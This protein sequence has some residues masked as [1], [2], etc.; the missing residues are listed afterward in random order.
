MSVGELVGRCRR[1]AAEGEEVLGYF[2]GVYGLAG[3][4]A[5]RERISER[6]APFISDGAASVGATCAPDVTISGVAAPA[7]LELCDRVR[8]EGER[9]EIDASLYP[10]ATAGFRLAADDGILVL[11][12]KTGSLCVLRPDERIAGVFNPTAENLELDLTRLAKSLVSLHCEARGMA[13]LHASG[14]VTSGGCVLFAGDSRN[15]KTTT[16]LESMAGF[17]LALLSC[18][19]S[20]VSET[21][22]GLRARGWPSNFSVSIG[23]MLDFPDLHPHLDPSMRELGYA[24]AW[25]IHP[26]HVLDTHAVSAAAGWETRPEADLEVIVALELSTEGNGVGIAPCSGEQLD[27]FLAGVTLGS[28]DPLYPDWHRYWQH[29]AVDRRPVVDLG[30]WVRRGRLKAYSMRWAPPP[31]TLLRR[32]PILDDVHRHTLSVR[33][34][35]S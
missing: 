18:D 11:V 21:G 1:V 30:E 25:G 27:E 4:P 3:P 19:T 5:M 34:G 33:G 31:Q 13:M 17:D 22:S 6:I 7:P 15:G 20:I 28:A 12:E 8:S 16:L 24:E 29:A 2:D 14:V 35:R 26:K 9:I 32:I 10:S 23:T